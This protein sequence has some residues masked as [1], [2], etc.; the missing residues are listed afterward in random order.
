MQYKKLFS[1]RQKEAAKVVS[2]SQ[3]ARQRIWYLLR[4]MDPYYVENDFNNWCISWEGLENRLKREHGWQELRAYRSQSDW[5]EVNP[6]EFILKGIPRFV[7]DATEIFWDMLT[8]DKE[9]DFKSKA[10]PNIYQHRLN[11]VFE[12]ANLP[13]R[14]LDG[15]IVRLDSEW[16]EREISAKARELL[17]VGG[18]DGALREFIEA[19]SELSA[20]DTKSAMRAANLALESTIKAVLNVEQEKPGKLIRKLIDSGL[21]P[22]YHEGF[23]KA[24]EEHILRAVPTARNFEKGVGHGQGVIVNEPPRSLADLAVNLA[25]VLILYLMKRHLE[26][27]PPTSVESKE[28]N[29]Q[30]DDDD[31]PF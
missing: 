29:K 20:G 6:K 23:L 31:V 17:A 1:K 2:L 12:E 21:V 7:L 30:E 15:R 26:M 14:M 9:Q 13:W 16:V 8:E 22:D 10:N 19:Q 27:N 25:G 3:S 28:D 4:D 5:E 11:I 24:F 18:F